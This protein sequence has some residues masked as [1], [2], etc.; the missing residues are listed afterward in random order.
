MIELSP[1]PEMRCRDQRRRGRERERVERGLRHFFVLRLLRTM[2]RSIGTEEEEAEEEEE[3][4]ED[5]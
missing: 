3:E 5:R 4:E 2:T 1:H